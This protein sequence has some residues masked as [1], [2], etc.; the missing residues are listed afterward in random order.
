M[1]FVFLLKYVLTIVET[2]ETVQK[3]LFARKGAQGHMIRQ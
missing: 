3:T 1:I 2:A